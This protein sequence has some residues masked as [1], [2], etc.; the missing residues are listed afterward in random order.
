MASIQAVR[1]TVSGTYNSGESYRKWKRSKAVA[2]CHSLY[3]LKVI[4]M[5]QPRLGLYLV[6]IKYIRNLSHADDHVMSVSPQVGKSTR[7][8]IG[9]IVICDEKQYCVPLSS[10]KEKHKSMKND[11]DFM[12]IFDGEKLIA[13]LNFNEMIP[14]RADVIRPLNMKAEKSDNEK[15]R[16]YKKLTIKQLS[17]CQKN[18]DAIVKKATRLYDLITSDKAN[19]NLKKRCCDFI[20]LESVLAKYK[21]SSQAN[22]ETA[23]QSMRNRAAQQGFMNDNEIE[24]A[25]TEARKKHD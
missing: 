24:M 12:K 19:Y 13:V 25:I 20:R 7:P 6:D 8:F 23:L 18:Q 21:S 4:N 22:A 10:P 16:R 5:N 14:V 3:L 11:V 2:H 17:F 1:P 9:V 15:A